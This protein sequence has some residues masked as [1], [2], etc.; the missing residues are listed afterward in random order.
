MNTIGCT[1]AQHLILYTDFLRNLGCPV[2][3]LLKRSRIPVYIE[4][5][6]DA[7]VPLK[8]GFDFVG[9]SAS[10]QGISDLGFQVSQKLN[11]FDL[12]S[13]FL[14]KAQFTPSSYRRLKLFAE[15]VTFEDN[16]LVC[17]IVA[18]N[19]NTR[20]FCDLGYPASG[21]ELRQS[22]WLQ[23]MSLVNIVRVS[24]G[25]DW[26]PIEITFK[27]EIAP[28]EAALKTFQR[29]RLLV[30]QA[31]TSITAPTISLAMPISTPRPPDNAL[32][33]WGDRPTPLNVTS[34]EPEH[35][36]LLLRDILEPYFAEGIP[37]VK[38][39][40]E[41]ANMSVRTLQRK[42]KNVSMSYSDILAQCRFQI[43]V[44]HLCDPGI[45][46]T[47]IAYQAGYTD[48]SNFSRAFRSVSG[49]SPSEFRSRQVT[50]A[51]A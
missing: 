44:K 30:G 39:A 48:P 21:Q 12:S 45:K 51:N 3:R 27:S 11:Y 4:E 35:F 24:L 13:E 6:P 2:D 17:G 43:A 29:T 23:V 42:L 25:P 28:C 32:Q 19:T 26:Q 50:E 41:I 33:Y 15:N 46:M 18:E 7:W 40:A 34:A 38:L 8:F 14:L 16:T 37:P 9:R 22:E 31:M 5:F 20:V 36:P 49:M 47:D 10:E 1:R